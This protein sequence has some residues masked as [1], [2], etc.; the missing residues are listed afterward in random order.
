M[1]TLGERIKDLRNKKGVTQE[2]LANKLS[3]NRATLANWEINRATPDISVL[4]LL[5]NY[6]K[7]S[8]DWLVTGQASKPLSTT[9]PVLGQIRAGSYLLS[10]EN[11]QGTLEI[12]VDIKADFA[13]IVQ[14]YSMIGAG[15]LEGDYA[16]CRQ[17]VEAKPGDIVVA[18]KDNASGFSES[19]L[20]YFF[21][22]NGKGAVLRAANPEFEDIPVNGEYRIAGIMVAQIRKE[23]PAYWVYRNYIST[24]DEALE[25]WNEV[26]EKG[27]QYGITPDQVKT[28]LEMHWS[29]AEKKVG[30]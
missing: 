9:I 6:F 1:N 20:K 21:T 14:G 7:V 19:T 4:P 30:R 8:I 2:E 18:L 10:D 12:P 22:D 16:I 13:L 28:M 23:P 15:I 26:I 5:A 11:Y 3:I 27:I 24:R 25:E 29:I 17:S